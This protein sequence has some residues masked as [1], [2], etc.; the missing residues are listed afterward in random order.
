M[1][2]IG[3]ALTNFGSRGGVADAPDLSWTP[4]AL[5]PA[6]WWDPSDLTTLFQDTAATT[7]VTADGQSVARINDKSGNGLHLIQPAAGL[8]PLYKTS[9]GLYWLESDGVDDLLYVNSTSALNFGTANFCVAAAI[10]EANNVGNYKVIFAKTN[11]ATGN[12]YRT[13]TTA[14]YILTT[15]Y[16]TDV[17][18]SSN[19]ALTMTVNTDAVAMWGR[20]ASNDRYELNASSATKAW[21]A[22]GVGSTSFNPTV[23]GDGSATYAF[24]GRIYSLVAIAAWPSATDLAKLKKYQ[25]AKAG[26]SL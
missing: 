4:A 18:P 17:Q 2:G 23:F 15:F 16:G 11:N 13:F 20:D 21:A 1:L 25:G 5:A 6:A 8:R 22:A 3:L 12:N 9:G 7:P 24:G 26:L 19:S 10:R 14:G